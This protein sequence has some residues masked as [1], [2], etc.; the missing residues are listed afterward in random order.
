MIKK[1]LNKNLNMLYTNLYD[2]RYKYA[3][4]NVA[5]TILDFQ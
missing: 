4:T 5:C 3:S 2:L 1:T